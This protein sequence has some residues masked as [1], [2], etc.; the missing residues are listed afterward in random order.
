MGK[1]RICF[2]LVSADK[3][4][5]VEGFVGLGGGRS[6]GFRGLLKEATYFQCHATYVSD[7]QE[8]AA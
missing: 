1:P 3:D 5:G 4:L 7:R 8:N 2:S 6:E